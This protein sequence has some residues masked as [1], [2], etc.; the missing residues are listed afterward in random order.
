[1]KLK[2]RAIGSSTGIVLPKETLTRLKVKR[3]DWLFALETPSGYL[4]M[5]YDKELEEQLKAG[6]QV[7]AE[8]RETLRALAKMR[9]PGKLSGT[10]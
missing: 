7:L 8:H 5:P 1:M 2:L 9:G 3:G 4:L 6:R 10:S